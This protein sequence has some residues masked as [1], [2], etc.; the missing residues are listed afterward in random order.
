M[1]PSYRVDVFADPGLPSQVVSRI[2]S[3]ESAHGGDRDG[4][5]ADDRK[6]NYRLALNRR[7]IPLRP[8]GTLDLEI[9]REWAQRDEADLMVIVTEIPRRAG[10][11]PKIAALHYTEGLAIISLPAL[12]AWD[13]S[14]KLRRMMFASLDALAD[15]EVPRRDDS[16]LGFGVVHEQESSTGP[17]VYIASPWWWPGRLRLAFGMVRINEPLA[18][19]SKLS[20]ALAAASA[21]GAFGIFYSSIWEMANALPPWRLG[22]VTL[23]VVLAMVLWLIASNGLWETRREHSDLSEAAMYNASTVMTLLVAVTLLYAVLFVGIFIAGLIIIESGYLAQT[24]GKSASIASYLEI[25]WLSASLGTVAGALGASF[26]HEDDI[27]NLTNGTRKAQRYEERKAAEK[28]E[29][30]GS[31]SDRASS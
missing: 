23:T 30:A 13:L 6:G 10:R 8:D 28:R 17:S 18:A 31:G 15:N 26:D 14:T 9:V 7:Q 27:R 22:L 24:I 12:G 11:R 16:R 21:T 4:D 5:S 19:A 20:G 25:A 3:A 2:L 1:R 29:S